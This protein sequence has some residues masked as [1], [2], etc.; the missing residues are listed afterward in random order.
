M[1]LATMAAVSFNTAAISAA[2]IRKAGTAELRS[3]PRAPVPCRPAVV[4]AT[5]SMAQP[6][7]VTMTRRAA[8]M[9]GLSACLFAASPVFAADINDVYKEQTLNIISEANN[10]I[11]LDK[12]DPTREKSIEVLRKDIN[13]WVAKYRREKRTSGKKSFGLVYS[14]LN[15]LQGHYTSF[16]VRAPLPAKRK[17][18]IVMELN[19]AVSDIGRGR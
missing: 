18:R 11:G 8:V 9:G 1:A 12:A 5:C 2:S 3:S 19:E 14:A 6:E 10:V 13:T 17:D 15:A 4:R 16:G 7:D